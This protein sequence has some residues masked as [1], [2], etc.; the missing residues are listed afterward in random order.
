MSRLVGV[1]NVELFAGAEMDTVGNVFVFRMSTGLL[2]L[3]S[4]E[5]RLTSNVV[6]FVPCKATVA[7]PRPAAISERM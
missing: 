7:M 5:L 2:E 6:L 1:G 3:V 4:F